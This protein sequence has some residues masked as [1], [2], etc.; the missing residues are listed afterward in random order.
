MQT[1][2][3]SVLAVSLIFSFF[4][5]SSAY[6][7][8]QIFI[9]QVQTTGGSGK[10]SEDFIELYNPGDTSINLKG[11]RL[12]KRTATASKDTLIKSWT[13]DTCVAKKSFFL[14]ANSN[15]ASIGA[16][17]NAT[18]TGEIADNNGVAI[19]FGSSDTGT[20]IDSIAWGVTSN[21]FRN[22]SPINPIAN[23]SLMRLDLTSTSSV[24][25]ILPSVP[26]SSAS[27][28]CESSSAASSTPASNI[29]TSTPEIL[30]STYSVKSSDVKISEILPNPEGEDSGLEKVELSNT[31]DTPVDLSGWYLG[32]KSPSGI[33]ANAY[34]LAGES[35][36]PG[37][38]LVITIP[39][40]FFVLNNTGGDV[41]NLYFADKTLADSV[42]F[43]EDA[44]E[45]WAYQKN[46]D[47]WVWGKPTLGKQNFMDSAEVLEN[48]E[49]YISEFMPN[50]E[51]ADEGKEWVEFKNTGNLSA[52]LQGFILDHRSS[53]NAAP[54]KDALV[55]DSSA[56]VPAGEY[57]IITIPE[58]KFRM[59][60][61]PEDGLRLFSPQN[62]FIQ[63]IAFNQAPEGQSYAR[64]AMGNW[65]FGAPTLGL[66]NFSDP[67]Q[68]NI[69]ISELLP[70]P[71]PDGQE[72]VE[73][74]N[75][76]G[77]AVKLKNLIL[78]IGARSQKISSEE[79]LEP[80]GYYTILE[81]DLPARLTNS[82]QTIILSDALGKELDRI[83]YPKAPPGEAYA[84]SGEDKYF[85]TESLTPGEQ[86][87]FVLAASTLETT[88]NIIRISSKEQAP[89]AKI[90]DSQVK[91]LLA[92][93]LELK[94]QVGNLQT[95]IAD[96]S[97]QV[98]ALA[99]ESAPPQIQGVE[100][101]LLQE[102]K[103][104]PKALIYLVVSLGALGGLSLLVW[105]F[106]WKAKA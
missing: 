4:I 52:S 101:G 106:F 76:G 60:N 26:R 55:L 74:Y 33:A 95:S 100:S 81:N 6:A 65:Q 19:R 68:S 62:K 88:P 64:D 99:A 21:S 98:L 92:D 13:S 84:L 8:D 82:G 15:F 96:L 94:N 83:D 105:K 80:G 91:I 87:K 20:I 39:Q 90:T 24:F 14:W 102:T 46:E 41:L 58:D 29:A 9:S 56:I 63:E 70:N 43:K 67:S 16:A 45:G 89:A 32:D 61:T 103:T 35:I 37:G 72:F 38:F 59:Q 40:D 73:I 93:N 44:R 12:V 48:R 51:G 57:L 47:T 69:I 10:T 71:G 54:G 104:Q 3:L 17:P 34:R 97:K 86:N 85:W 30:G 77:S 18:T 1:K 78:K 23:Q 75:A 53:M 5:Y 2:S 49:V 50:P 7:A 42:S 22:V 66:A 28:A 31:G 36:L 79:N 11:Y 27:T 25:T